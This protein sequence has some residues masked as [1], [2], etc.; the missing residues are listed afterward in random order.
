MISIFAFLSSV[1]RYIFIAVIY[2]FIFGIIRMIIL[3]IK[4]MDMPRPRELPKDMP[5][6]QL[7]TDKKT[8][9]FDVK[10]AYPLDR[11]IIIVGRGEQCDICID[12][13]YLSTQHVQL[14]YEDDEWYIADLG[15]TNGTYINGMK[16]SDEPF[17]LDNGD[18]IKAGQLEFS[19]II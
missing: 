5:Y 18:R 17:I 15:S 4:R 3:D 12:D 7:L 16:M 1:F 13:L 8:L 9:Y 14:W 19:A 11:D 2:L 10:T 6:L